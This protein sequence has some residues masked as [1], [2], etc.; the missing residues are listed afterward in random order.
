MLTLAAIVFAL[1]G[2]A[3]ALDCSK[4]RAPV[5][6]MVCADRDLTALDAKLGGLYRRALDEGQEPETLRNSQREWLAQRDQCRDAACVELR[7]RERTGRLDDYLDALNQQDRKGVDFVPVAEADRLCLRYVPS[8]APNA[9]VSC[10][11]ADYQVLGDVGGLRRIYALYAIRY[12][13]NG[14]NLAMAAPVVLNFSPADPTLLHFDFM[15]TDAPG[16]MTEEAPKGLEPRRL[17]GVDGD[18]LVFNLPGLNGGRDVRTWRLGRD[19]AWAP[20]R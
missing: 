17:T 3:F 19:G 8:T 4:A 14:Q 16:L 15:I 20:T 18:R 1:A 12:R 5:E 13:W 10:R 9:E 6:T 2:P 7:Y 11:V